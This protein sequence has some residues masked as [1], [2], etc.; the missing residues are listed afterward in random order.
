MHKENIPLGSLYLII[1]ALCFA[2][3]GAIVKF[4][5]TRIGDDQI[6][7]MRNFIGLLILLPHLFVMKGRDL[8]TK[9]FHNHFIRAVANV[10]ALYCLFYAIRHILLADAILLNNTMPLFVPFV[11]LV[12]NKEKVPKAIFLPLIIAFVGVILVLHPGLNLIHVA[13]IIALFSGLFMAISTVGVRLLGKHEPFYRI[14]FYTFA[15]TSLIT[16]FPLFWHW[17]NPTTLAWL[18]LIGVGVFGFGYQ[19]LIIKAYQIAS[20]TKIS[21]L[22]FLSVVVSGIYDW[23]F[24]DQIP[25]WISYVGLV[26]ILVGSYL[27]T[28]VEV[29]V[30][31]E[32][33]K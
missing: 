19:F 18:A 15:I 23:I 8:K 4:L 1:A 31:H 5:S 16:V 9:F 26:L 29:K 30:H 27:C 28:R 3:M 11:L 10:L 14:M 22:I 17:Q 12:W 33:E 24:W 25:K 2:T 13:S 21:P 6:L 7:F 32:D 20:P